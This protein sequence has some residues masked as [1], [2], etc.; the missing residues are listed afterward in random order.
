MLKK[1]YVTTP[2]Y[3]VNDVPHIGHTCTTV[4]ADILARYHRL[5]G[6]DT[7]FL[8]GTDEHGAKVAEAATKAG[9]SPKDYC[10]FIAPK[11]ESNWLKINL[12]FNAFIRT[13]NP[14][15]IKIVQELTQKTYDKGDIYKGVYE[16]LYCVGCEKFVTESELVDGKCPLHNRVPEKLKEENYFFK[17]SKYVDTLIRAIE[18]PNDKNHFEIN[19]IS[20]RNE[21]LSKLKL[22]DIP[23][24]SISRQAKVV[25][26]G[27]PIP[28]D[29]SQ[30]I[31]VWFDALP[32][33]Y[34]ATKIFDRP[35]F[36]ENMHHTIAKDIAWFHAV[37][38]T[39]MLISLELPLPKEVFIHSYFM[40][41][42]QKMSKSLGNVITP[43]DLIDR[44]GVDGARFLIAAYFPRDDDSDVGFSRFTQ[45]Y[46]SD[47][48]NNLGN[49]F[50][51]FTRLAEQVKLKNDEV[52]STFK[53][54][55]ALES[56]QIF[57]TAIETLHFSQAVED[58]AAKVTVV[59]KELQ[60]AKPWEIEDAEKRQ[61]Y[62]KTLIP[63]ILEIAILISPIIPGTSE[64]L[65]TGLS[66][67]I[68]F[69][70]ALFPR[71]SS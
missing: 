16:G 5:L 18:D 53:D 24:T 30:T 50:S 70:G 60:E 43:Q 56:S 71:V 69:I 32:N 11:F 6:D 38:W 62:L 44:Y 52:V 36:F 33:Y 35:G 64:K 13:T 45:K 19:P 14:E 46:N 68:K 25:P 42:G 3:Y 22:G 61:T 65:V 15:H 67:E 58:I 51:R 28:W 1:Y 57:K 49:L 41:D 40:V 59:N 55:I 23:D 54:V 63:K 39:A 66:G 2:I 10:D 17:L 34:T 7:F 37:L 29:N 27:I 20:K 12:S 31:Y 26:W 21:I 8:T 48:A 47:L 4:A 9:M